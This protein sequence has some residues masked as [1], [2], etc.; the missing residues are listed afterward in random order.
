M[1]KYW[2]DLIKYENISNM[3][4]LGWYCGF[5]EKSAKQV[6]N[7]TK[8]AP[9]LRNRSS[10]VVN[11]EHL[12]ETKWVKN[13]HWLTSISPQVS[14]ANYKHSLITSYMSWRRRILFF[15]PHNSIISSTYYSNCW[16]F[17]TLLLTI[18]LIMCQTL[19][20]QFHN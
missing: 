17:S 7:H 16:L 5:W 11:M 13:L 8:N 6:K 3:G 14:N 10:L 2:P 1:G 9:I 4:S 18:H 20:I 19:Q 15:P 12:I